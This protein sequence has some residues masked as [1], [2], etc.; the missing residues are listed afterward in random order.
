MIWSAPASDNGSPITG[1]TLKATQGSTVKTITAAASASSATVTGLANG[2]AA[3][4]SV[5][6]VNAKGSSAASTGTGTPKALNLPGAPKDLTV[7]PAGSGT[8]RVTWNPPDDPGGNAVTQY[9]ITYQQVVPD[10]AGTGW[11]PTPGTT[12]KTAV[13]AGTATS[14]TIAAISPA[15]ALYSFSLSATTVAGTGGS[16]TTSAPVS[17]TTSLNSGTVV[18]TAATMT[19]ATTADGAAFTWPAPA[20]AQIS[21][22]KV[23]QV[24]VAA[25]APAAP[26]GLLRTVVAVEQPTTGTYRIATV[27][28]ALT[29]AFS[30]LAMSQSADPLSVTPAVGSLAARFTPAAAGVRVL[31]P[32][33]GS[34]LVTVSTNLTLGLELKDKKTGAFVSGEVALEPTLGVGLSLHHGFL[35]VP[36]GVK[37]KASAELKADMSV[38]AG[39]SSKDDKYEWRVGEID[40]PPIVVELVPPAFLVFVPKVPVFF[41]IS[42]K[43]G[44]VVRGTVTLGGEIGWDSTK[45]A[46][47]DAKNTSKPPSPDG[48]FL[49]GLSATGS[50]TAT[51]EPEAE[52]ALYDRAG[53]TYGYGLSL[54][55]KIDAFPAPG[56]P[57]LSITPSVT[58]TAGLD[59]KLFGRE[60]HL[61]ATLATDVYPPWNFWTK[62]G[63]VLTIT[64]AAPTVAPG[65][66]VTFS[67]TRS[68]G[69][70]GHPVTWSLTGAA[71]D[72]IT[73]AGVL[74][75]VLPGARDLTVN[76]QDDAGGR[77]QT[78]VHVGAVFDPPGSL[79]VTPHTTDSGATVAW[80]APVNT[81]GSAIASYVVTTDPS[82]GPHPVPASATS[83]ELPP[84]A[85]GSS[86]LVS[87]Y[88]TNA[89]GDVSPPATA[90]LGVPDR[91]PACPSALAYGQE[92]LCTL[93]SAG[94]I[95][96][97]RLTAAAGDRM[98][99]HV[100]PTTS[101]SALSPSLDVVSPTGAAVC[102]RTT[103]DDVDCTAPVSGVYTATVR[104]FFGSHTGGYAVTPQRLN[105][106]V[107]CPTVA[108][109]SAATGA[110][111][112]G[113]VTCHRVSAS[114][115][116]RMRW[117]VVPTSSGP[118]SPTVDV[119]TPTGA[120][121]CS[122]TTLDD[123]DCTAST[124]GLYTITVADFIGPNIGNYAV[125][126]QRLN[127]PVGCTTVAYG[128]AASGATASGG[129]TCHRVSASAGDRMR[130]HVVPTSSGPLS[131][132]VDVLTPTGAVA[133]SRT[134]LDDVDCTASTTGLY[135]I[136]VA[137]FIGP[138]TGNYAATPQRLNNPVGCTA[139]TYGSA[140]G[141]TLVAGQVN[142][143]R[144]TA[145]AGRVVHLHTVPTS[146]TLSPSIDVIDPAGQVTC[147]AT[148]LDDTS[149]TAP[150][151]GVYTITVRDFFGRN[152][153]AYSITAT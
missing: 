70:T 132:T 143:H 110:T 65:G 62:P 66:S 53:P 98:R 18:L 82:T 5:V 51:L 7:A 4:V 115:G 11:V 47:L 64:P 42:G 28:A 15:T 101:G 114:A 90:Q 100:V 122:R 37:L 85:P 44:A 73:P 92:A 69:V 54:E 48:G 87:V 22:L 149:C 109:G 127:N 9:T 102:S 49:P 119:L 6:A 83:F 93:T 68:D 148:T 74:T 135:T 97:F 153:G 16:A 152:T 31:Q 131:P 34:S 20:P 29:D 86:Y 118:L 141:G 142:C 14:A 58:M 134:T 123:V 95:A 32:H 67:A 71:G 17:P 91:P 133:C 60:T 41:K 128:S 126:A 38:T 113:G 1:Y 104:D 140:T 130:W 88:A 25:P 23:G 30:A 107:G 124:T 13:A 10:S 80:T 136:T 81:G 99:W 24:I 94:Q 75:T 129:V 8:V 33:T 55:A 45:P 12:P 76:A 59:L 96:G 111:A 125:T 89:A 120:V 26:H 36:D 72:A 21:G 40:G 61:E 56:N 27:P 2:V 144:L 77:G 147:S 139:L 84:L 108:Y 121:A 137:D 43:V 39:F 105:N 103:L 106:P 112:L 145:S 35:G 117:H 151:S 63:P 78:I 57:Y 52:V 150:V 50:L 3:S 46:V 79:K 19:N 138:N 146:G 116:D